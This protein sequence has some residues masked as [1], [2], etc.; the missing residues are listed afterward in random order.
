VTFM[1]PLAERGRNIR[2]APLRSFFAG[3]SV[4]HR[5][6]LRRKHRVVSLQSVSPSQGV[7]G[8]RLAPDNA[9]TDSCTAGRLRELPTSGSEEA[10][11]VIKK[12][13]VSCP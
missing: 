4:R 11:S 6:S 12:Q 2:C 3:L 5:Y 1:T 13:P 9:E 10:G 8:V 7:G